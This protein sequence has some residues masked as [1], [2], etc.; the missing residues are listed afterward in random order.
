M[1][2]FKWFITVLVASVTLGLFTVASASTLMNIKLKN[3]TGGILKLE[4]S[5]IGSHPGNFSWHRKPPQELA[6]GEKILVVE[7]HQTEFA[8]AQVMFAELKYYLASDPSN[9]CTI[10][11]W[12]NKHPGDDSWERGNRLKECTGN[13]TINLEREN[14]GEDNKV[15]FNLKK[16]N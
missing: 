5:E 2:T 12:R 8:K 14:D 10:I 11:L 13:L 15:V 1:K 16:T 9:R 7:H 3:E 4:G 6:P